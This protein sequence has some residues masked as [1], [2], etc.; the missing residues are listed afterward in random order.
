MSIEKEFYNQ[1]LPMG[2]SPASRGMTAVEVNPTGGVLNLND[3]FGPTG[4][5]GHFYE[6]KAAGQASG[7]IFVAASSS[8]TYGIQPKNFALGATGGGHTGMGWPLHPGQSVFGRMPLIKSESAPT[9]LGYGTGGYRSTGL[10]AP[11]IHFRAPPNMATGATLYIRQATS[12]EGQNLGEL[13]GF[14]VPGRA[15][16]GSM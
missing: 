5:A 9:L 4:G 15:A 14:P 2:N 12:G 7:A 3:V 13:A 8:P 16:P 1:L 11:Y 6:L 10:P